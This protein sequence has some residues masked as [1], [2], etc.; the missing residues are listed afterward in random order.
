MRQ[1][2]VPTIPALFLAWADMQFP[3]PAKLVDAVNAFGHQLADWKTAYY[4]EDCG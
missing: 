4:A 3:M 2:G 1:L